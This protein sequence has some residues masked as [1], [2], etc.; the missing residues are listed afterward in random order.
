MNK[1][2][3]FFVFVVFSTSPEFANAQ[4][5]SDEERVEFN[6]NRIGMRSDQPMFENIV[7]DLVEKH[8][9]SLPLLLKVVRDEDE[10]E[11]ERINA[12]YIIG[13]MGPDA[14]SAVATLTKTLSSRS[15]STEVKA[16]S[17]GAL[18]RIG[19]KA[20]SAVTALS[21]HLKHKNKW[22]Q[23]QAERAL[24]SIR[25]RR[26]KNALKEHKD[27]L[28]EQKKRQAMIDQGIDPDSFD[29]EDDE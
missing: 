10:D 6:M 5:M 11:N 20:N 26:A 13:R 15:S 22:V 14:A 2:V 7:H 3:I 29:E 19:R 9:I 21:T 24:K 27:Y 1:L 16:V 25:T 28:R 4:R 12:I 23:E 18:G 17:A 8:E